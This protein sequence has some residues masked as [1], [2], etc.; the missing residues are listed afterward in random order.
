M[1]YNCV[2]LV[3]Q[4]P[5][6]KRITGQAMNEDGTV[7]RAA[8]PAIF[9]PEDL[10]ALELALQI[11]DQYGGT[12]TV[13][14]MGLPAA[15]DVLREGL[16]RG[17]DRAVLITDRRCAASDTL[18]T[19]YILSCGVKMLHPDIVLCG[20]QAIDGDTAQ[21]GPQVAEKLNLPQITYVEALLSLDGKTI[22]AKRNLGNGWQEVKSRLPVL[23]TVIDAANEPRV[24]RAKQLMKYKWAK[25]RIEVEAA[26]QSNPSVDVEAVCR[27]LQT[28]G[29]LID[30]WDLDYLKADLQW[31][32][33]DGS[34][35]KVHRIQSVVLSAKESKTIEPTQSGID[36]MIHELIVDHTIG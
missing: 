11:K 25:C 34:P 36:A 32:G 27:D 2:V 13:M 22:V 4:V 5:D 30:Q 6:T 28:R 19:S 9:N 18:A 1:G 24:P 12:V 14:T 15:A 3:K 33:R 7:N 21:V 26:A 10:N 29:L 35:T 8:L 23:L 17:A 16:Y 20:R 31:C